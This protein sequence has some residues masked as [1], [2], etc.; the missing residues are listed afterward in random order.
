[1]RI[2]D[3]S[4]DVFSSDLDGV[5]NLEVGQSRR[6]RR[7]GAVQAIPG[8]ASGRTQSR[9]SRIASVHE[10][11]ESF[12]SS[13]TS[14]QDPQLAELFAR[15]KDDFLS[16]TGTGRSPHRGALSRVIVTG[17]SRSFLGASPAHDSRRRPPG[18]EA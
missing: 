12:R 15:A 9:E 16:L 8:V 5:S 13:I 6:T 11:A 1:M 4:S 7:T 18:G 3:W 14:F 2:S 17:L 10:L